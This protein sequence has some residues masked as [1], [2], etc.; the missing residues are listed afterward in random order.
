MAKTKK[1]TVAE[2][3]AQIGYGKE[4]DA[5]AIVAKMKK[6]TKVSDKKATKKAS[7]T[8][9]EVIKERATKIAEKIKVEEPKKQV[10]KVHIEPSKDNTCLEVWVAYKQEGYIRTIWKS[11]PTASMKEALKLAERYLS[12]IELAKVEAIA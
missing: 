12:Q 6:P 7:K 10:T 5:K 9:K 1:L 3:D 8:D 2:L 11:Y 4:I